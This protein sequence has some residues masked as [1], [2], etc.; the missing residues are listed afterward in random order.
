[1]STLTIAAVVAAGR[2][3]AKARPDVVAMADWIVTRLETPA[4]PLSATA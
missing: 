3:T 4:C 1:M 2:L